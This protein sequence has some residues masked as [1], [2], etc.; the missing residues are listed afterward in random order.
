MTH[1]NESCRTHHCMDSS[2]HT[3]CVCVREKSF[4]VC[5]I[6]L[7][8][9]AVCCSVLQCLHVCACVETWESCRTRSLFNGKER[10]GER[11]CVCV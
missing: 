6:L 10:E 5:Y 3:V 9:V 8:C 11:V 4:A 1:M 2:I 7:Q